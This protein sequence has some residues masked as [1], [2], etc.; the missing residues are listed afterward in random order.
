MSVVDLKTGET[1][2]LVQDA[3]WDAVDGIRWTPWGTLLIAEEVAGGRLVEIFLD[4]DLMTASAVVDRPTVG[5]IAHEGIDLGQDGNVY[6]VDEHRGRSQGCNGVV[7]CGGGIYR[8]VPDTYG[9]LSSGSLY[10]LAVTGAD[11]VGQGVF[12]LVR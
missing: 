2:L 3:T 12:G 11:G 10:A 9:D 5:R 7:P 8:F 4:A 1:K 6:V